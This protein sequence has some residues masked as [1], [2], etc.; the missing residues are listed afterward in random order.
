MQYSRQDSLQ[1]PPNSGSPNSA[2]HSAGPNAARLIV[3][4]GVVFASFSS[5]IIRFSTAPPLVIA[6]YRMCFASVVMLPLF[7]RKV[8]AEGERAEAGDLLRMIVGGLFLG[9]HFAAWI[10]SLG[11]TSV[12]SSVILV[13]TH[14]I[15]VFFLSRLFFRERGSAAQLF[16]VV[17]AI[18]GSAVLTFGD[19][20]G[21][22]TAL[23]GNLLAFLGGM[24]VGLYLIVGR[25]V[26]RRVSLVYYTFVVYAT[27]A[28]F[29]LA[30]AAAAGNPLFGYAPRE[31][32]LFLSLAL[33]CTLLGHSLYN[34]SLKYLNPTFVS[35]T[36]LIEPVV[37]STLA[38]FL[39][40]EF[41]AP[42]SALGAMIVLVAIFLY[43]RSS[44]KRC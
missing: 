41:P 12:A 2:G 32:L 20:G 4:V 27:S 9:I 11:L 37:A 16:Y 40:D 38:F 18:F 23:S 22:E 19:A 34:W 13:T 29:L 14:P 8:F 5:I 17:M 7:L 35:V 6:F 39:F 31:W 25:S 24:T 28:L 10:T 44:R 30:G 1:A 3:V 21:G 15:L 42:V 36:V 26:R 43:G 33:V